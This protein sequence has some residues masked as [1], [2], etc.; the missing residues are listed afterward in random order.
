[1]ITS[2]CSAAS[3]ATSMLLGTGSAPVAETLSTVNATHAMFRSR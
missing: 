1:M 3:S 2:A